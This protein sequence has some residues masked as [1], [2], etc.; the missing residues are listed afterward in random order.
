MNKHLLRLFYLVPDSG[1][2]VITT[3]NFRSFFNKIACEEAEFF[4][5][6][7]AELYV[8]REILEYPINM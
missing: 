7:A 5:A 1:K 6:D 4:R 3:A 8:A 2:V